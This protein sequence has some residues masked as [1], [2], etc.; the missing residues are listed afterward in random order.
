MVHE[1]ENEGVVSAERRGHLLMIRIDRQKKRNGFTPKMFR[2]LGEAYT[3]LERDPE[4]RVGV[5]FAEGDHFSAGIDLPKMAEMRASGQPYVPLNVVDPFQIREPYRKKP[6]IVAVQ[7]IAYTVTMELAMAADI[8]IAAED[9]R[10][11]Q[12]EVRRGIM[13][14]LGGSF[15]LIQR[16]G[17]GNA[18]VWLLTGDEFS[19]QEAYRIG[20]VQEV[21]PTGRQLHRAVELAERI[22]ERAPLAVQATIETCRKSLGNGQAAAATFMTATNTELYRSEDAAEGRQS[23]LEKREAIFNGR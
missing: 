5:V 22:A 10:F 16:A 15:R 4:L 21:V 11:S 13:A 18:M 7:G 12:T 3:L 9:C 8:V 20:L 17:W 2:E 1:T 14:G 6:V 23:F 19:A